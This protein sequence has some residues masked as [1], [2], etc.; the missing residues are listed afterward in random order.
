[1]LTGKIRRNLEF[2]VRRPAVGEQ[3]EGQNRLSDISVADFQRLLLL[4]G[5]THLEDSFRS[6]LSEFTGLDASAVL[7]RIIVDPGFWTR[8]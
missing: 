1:V 3:M 5:Q 4:P 8:Q 2:F 6:E 7:N